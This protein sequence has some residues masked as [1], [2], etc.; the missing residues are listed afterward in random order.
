VLVNPFDGGCGQELGAA[1]CALLVLAVEIYD[2]DLLERGV[3]LE[4]GDGLVQD[5]DGR[6]GGGERRERFLFF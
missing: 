5:D 2:F 6:V 4:V 1:R 3:P